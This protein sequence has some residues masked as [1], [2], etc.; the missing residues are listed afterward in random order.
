MLR[1]VLF[2]A[3]SVRLRVGERDVGDKRQ[4]SQRG[5]RFFRYGRAAAQTSEDPRARRPHHSLKERLERQR[6]SL[7]AARKHDRHVPGGLEAVARRRDASDGR[8]QALAPV[9]VGRRP[10]DR[11]LLGNHVGDAGRTWENARGDAGIRRDGSRRRRGYDLDV[12]RRRGHPRLGSFRGDGKSEARRRTSARPRVRFS[13]DRHA[14]LPSSRCPT[15]NLA[16]VSRSSSAVISPESHAKAAPHRAIS[17]DAAGSYVG[18]ITYRT[19]RSARQR[20]AIAAAAA[21]SQRAAMRRAQSGPTPH[22]ISQRRSAAREPS[23]QPW[24]HCGAAVRR[25]GLA[26][27][28]PESS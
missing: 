23:G 24:A 13:A 27:A 17:G 15:A 12:P 19:T 21:R 5:A 8:R 18:T 2:D 7:D 16:A 4:R 20:S 22:R 26:R 6:Q 11:H 10:Y 1:M 25:S 3:K 28:G 9:V 14:T